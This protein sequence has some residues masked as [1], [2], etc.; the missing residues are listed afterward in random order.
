M[1]ILTGGMPAVIAAVFGAVQLLPDSLINLPAKHYWLAPER[2]KESLS[3]LTSAGLWFAS[4]DALFF[5][6]V[7][8]LILQ[9]NTKSPPR[10]SNAIWA[11]LAVMLGGV[12]WLII[13]GLRKFRRPKASLA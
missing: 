11:M 6:G 2:R 1:L 13:G 4:L 5:L 7:H 8:F 12:L 9:A 10:L 3:W